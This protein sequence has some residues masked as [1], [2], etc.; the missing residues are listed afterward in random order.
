MEEEV[1]A[2]AES[3][4]WEQKE[5]WAELAFFCWGCEYTLS[6]CRQV[7]GGQMVELVQ[8]GGPGMKWRW[9]WRCSRVF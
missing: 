8:E 1:W 9:F 3:G 5:G 2:D 6:G 7:E 4:M